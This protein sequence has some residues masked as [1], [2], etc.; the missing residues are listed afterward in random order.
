MIR[1]FLVLIIASVS[2]SAFAISS[3]SWSIGANFSLV[4]ADQDDMDTVIQAAD[5]DQNT[6]ASQVGNGME[7]G[8][9]IGYRFSNG[10]ELLVRPSYYMVGEDGKDG[11]NASYEYEMT[12]ISVMPMLR[13]YLLENQT[14]A[15]YSQLGLGYTM[16]SG[17][18]EEDGGNIEFS[19]SD[20]GYA[21]GL[22]AEFCFFGAHCFYLEG[23]LRIASVDRM[24]VDKFSAGGYSNSAISQSGKGQELEINNRDFGASLSGIQGVVGYN[25]HF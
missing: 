5:T 18:I 4:N 12:A 16:M 2:N 9:S 17:T 22:G 14:I 23:N 24:T 19:G 13:F 7:F 21:G 10:V 8:A 3:G 25:L 15:F 11:S 1:I 6:S 20:L